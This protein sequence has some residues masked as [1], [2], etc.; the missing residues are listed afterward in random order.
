MGN[1]MIFKRKELKYLLDQRQ[2]EALLRAMEPYMALD[3]Y[4]R[5]TIRNLYF[6]T[7]NFRL[8]RRSME[9]PIY[10]EKLRV[11]SYRQTR[12]DV[13]VFVELKKKYRSV[14]Y[15]RRLSLTER[16]AMEC[17][18]KGGALPVSSQIAEEIQY[19]CEFYQDLRPQV[20]LAYEREAF[21]NLA[22]GDFRVTFD[23]NILYRREALS[24]GTEVWGTPLLE[25]GQT[26][27][28]IKTVGSIPLW[29]TQVLSQEQIFRTSYSKYGSAYQRM[30]CQGQEG[31]L[32][33]A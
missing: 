18:R 14:V 26:L 24:L 27:M 20:F 21:Y 15:K 22:G 11:R 5:T 33:Y 7:D 1:Q 9:K 23:E 8:V 3:G 19:F 4:G 17:L 2:K 12:P 29:M 30:I 31:G 32:L 25:E 13:P 28:E 6:D 10:K 16:Q